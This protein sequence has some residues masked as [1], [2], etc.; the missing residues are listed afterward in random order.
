[1]PSADS[2]SLPWGADKLV[3]RDPA[4]CD[5]L[6][7]EATAPR[8][9]YYD[10]PPAERFSRQEV[11]FARMGLG[12]LEEALGRPKGIAKSQSKPAVARFLKELFG[13]ELPLAMLLSGMGTPTRLI[14][15]QAWLEMVHSYPGDARGV[16]VF[17]GLQLYA[18][19]RI[20]EPLSYVPVQRD[21]EV[22]RRALDNSWWTVRPDG[23]TRASVP[24]SRWN[25]SPQRY[26]WLDAGHLLDEE[27]NALRKVML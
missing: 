15:L 23:P 7:A 17:S 25:T 2:L 9:Y 21:V 11:E 8:A 24:A 16:L 5:A 27:G 1:M 10:T 13:V 18:D 3:V 4:W 20:G 14:A 26:F 22:Q 6:L 19:G 12:D